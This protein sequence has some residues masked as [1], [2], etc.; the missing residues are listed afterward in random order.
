MPFRNGAHERVFYGLSRGA[1][2][3]SDYST[4]IAAPAEER[5]GIAIFPQDPAALDDAVAD[6]LT[7]PLDDA[8]AAGR[9]WYTQ[10]HTWDHRAQQIIELMTPLL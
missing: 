3:L 8:V 10:H 1:A 2:I 9:R 4:L 7:H 5:L 6:L